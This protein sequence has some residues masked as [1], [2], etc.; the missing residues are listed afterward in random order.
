MP[1]LGPLRVAYIYA[2]PFRLVNPYGLFAVMTTKRD[3]IVIEG[4]DDGRVWRTYEF[5]FKPGDVGRRPPLV[6]PHMPRLDWQMWFAALDDWRG[7][8]WLLYFC[9][10]LLQGS[11]P[12]SALMAHDPFAGRAP[13]EVRTLLYRYRFTTGAEQRAT[14]AWWHRELVAPYAPAFTLRDG[15]LAP[16]EEPL[17]DASAPRDSLDRGVRAH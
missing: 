15:Q 8:D 11:P 4:S 12:V 13:R 14:G 16:A 2:Q 17:P 6:A 1:W 7:E 9:L 10:R 3:E 5:R